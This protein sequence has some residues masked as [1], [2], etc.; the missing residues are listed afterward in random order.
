ML[1]LITGRSPI[2]QGRYIVSELKKAMDR[3]EDLYNLHVFIDP[4]KNQD[5]LSGLDFGEF[6]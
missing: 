3:T 5:T 2:E 6:C 4:V 1:E